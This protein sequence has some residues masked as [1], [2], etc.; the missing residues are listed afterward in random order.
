MSRELENDL[1]TLPAV[2]L[3]SSGLI[4]VALALSYGLI[5]I[6][7]APF[8]LWFL[9]PILARHKARPIA[10]GSCWVHCRLQCGEYGG[11][12]IK[13][14]NLCLYPFDTGLQEHAVIKQ[15]SMSLSFKFTHTHRNLCC[16]TCSGCVK[17]CALR[18]SPQP[19]H[20]NCHLQSFEF[21]TCFFKP[22][23]AQNF[24]ILS[25]IVI[26]FPCCVYKAKNIEWSI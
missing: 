13:K 18:V 3:M 2:P 15:I 12:L 21:L 1:K 6:S 4:N 20:G 11:H 14:E 19:R 22:S 9:Q 24:P 5:D 26:R 25:H 16:C 7:L 17:C 8:Y 23:A 10:A